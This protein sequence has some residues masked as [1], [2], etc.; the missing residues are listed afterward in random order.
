VTR[1]QLLE[2]APGGLHMKGRCPAPSDRG[3]KRGSTPRF[4]Y[5]RI[6]LLPQR[7]ARDVR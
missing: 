7:S 3:E 6:Q 1:G 5:E 4:L 2:Q